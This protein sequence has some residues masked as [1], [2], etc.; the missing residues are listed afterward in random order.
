MQ[1]RS[2]Q[3]EELEFTEE[4][5]ANKANRGNSSKFRASP[6]KSRLLGS[7]ISGGSNALNNKAA[8]SAAS[9]PNR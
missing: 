3:K 8:L 6:D 4:F 5:G 7:G 1:G 9:S 2:N